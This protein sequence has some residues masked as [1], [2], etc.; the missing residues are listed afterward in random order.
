MP[1]STAIYGLATAVGIGGVNQ[2]YS[3][4][5]DSKDRYETFAGLFTLFVS[6]VSTGAAAQATYRAA[7][8]FWIPW[9]ARSMYRG[10]P[11]FEVIEAVQ[12]GSIDYARI[13]LRQCNGSAYDIR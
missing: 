9:R 4:I 11:Y 5:R 6:I 10:M 7:P 3:E 2:G 13:A 8:D 1:P 12:N